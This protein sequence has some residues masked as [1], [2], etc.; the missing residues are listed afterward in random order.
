MT[1]DELVAQMESRREHKRFV[2]VPPRLSAESR[3]SLR[4][5]RVC[6]C[7]ACRHAHCYDFSSGY[8]KVSRE[9]VGA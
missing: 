4:L 7:H 2:W 9:T 5:E 1:F 6:T 8:L 3:G